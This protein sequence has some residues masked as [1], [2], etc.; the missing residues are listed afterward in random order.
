MPYGESFIARLVDRDLTV[1][2]NP[3]RLGPDYWK[4]TRT[5]LSERGAV[6]E[7]T[8]SPTCM[9]SHAAVWSEANLAW[10][11]S[12][13]GDKEDR[14]HFEVQGRPPAGFEAITERRVADQKADSQRDSYP[15]DY[16]FEIPGEVPGSVIDF[17]CTECLEPDEVDRFHLIKN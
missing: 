9:A 11:I 8:Y 2:G 3:P 12:H 4:A 13:D 7:A 10:D 17:T 5:R 14:F 15:L 6:Y 16:I 1:L